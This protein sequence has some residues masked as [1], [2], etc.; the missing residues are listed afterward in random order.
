MTY[1]TRL[2]AEFKKLID[3]AIEAAK[4]RLASGQI[5]TFEEYKMQA[6][7]IVGLRMALDLLQEAFSTV[8][9]QS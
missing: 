1:D 5:P 6:G 4:E 3:Q 2:T 9:Q 8:N 7:G